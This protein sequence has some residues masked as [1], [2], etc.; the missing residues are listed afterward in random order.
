[1]FLRRTAGWRHCLTVLD[2]CQ[3]AVEENRLPLQNLRT[4]LG[5][6]KPFGAIKFRKSLPLSGMWRPFHLEHIALEVGRLPV[7][8][9]CPYVNDLASR[10]S[11][12]AKGQGLG[13]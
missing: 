2:N 11:R 10:L 5:N 3:Q 9:H 7:V 12:F 4:S 1:M 13:A 6:A 8:F